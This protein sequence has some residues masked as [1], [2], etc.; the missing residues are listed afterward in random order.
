MA[1]DLGGVS[2]V[3]LP[4]TGSDDEYL[5]RAFAEPLRSAGSRLVAVAPHPTGLVAGYLE[6]LDEAGAHGAIAVGGVSLG[7]AV[8]AAWALRHPH[9]VVA[10]LTALPPWTG[11]PGRA[12]AALSARHTAVLLRRDGLDAAVATMASSSPE[13]LA[14]ELSR[15]WRR[16]WP[17]LPDALEE[18]AGYVAPTAEQLGRLESPMG[19]AG[20]P[21]DPIHPLDVAREWAAAAPR[22]ALCTVPLTRFGPR[23]EALGA[24]CLEALSRAV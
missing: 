6:A 16:Q 12:P 17:A 1:V 13:W 7:A 8:A 18:A 21:D 20:A 4:G 9:R 10:V 24:A 3:L 11:P 14:D 19:V 22:A 2:T 23:P 15:S 5:R